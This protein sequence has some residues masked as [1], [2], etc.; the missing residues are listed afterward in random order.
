[1]TLP[2]FTDD[3]MPSGGRYVLGMERLLKAVQELSLVRDLE[4]VQQIVRTVARELTGCDG[5]SFVLN[6]GGTHCYYADEDAIEPLWKGLRFPQEICVSGWVM[7]HGQP[8]VIPD[9]YA[10]P[11]VPYEAYRPTFVKSMVMVPI[12]AMAPIGAIG[13]YWAKAHSPT[14]TEVRLLQ[15]LAD[16]TSVA[17]E[18]VSVYAELEHRVRARTEDL[19]RAHLEIQQLAVTDELTG[20]LNRRGFYEAA[21][22]A[23]AR[24]VPILLVSIDADGLK[25]VNDTLGHA[26]GDTMLADIAETLRTCFRASDIIA[27]M[28][29]DEYCVM[30]IDPGIDEAALREI[31]LRRIEEANAARP[32]AY[33]LAASFG[34]IAVP[35][36]APEDLDHW[37]IEVDRRMYVEK[38]ARKGRVRAV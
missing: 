36:A 12:R 25:G 35:D 31:L 29:G 32:R 6:E 16:A 7:R 11:R 2:S 30:M 20:L 13:N 19:T 15:A 1:M 17:M 18:N 8:A 24:K 4:G 14:D 37:L 26:V 21:R 9:I 3:P 28:G 23:L 27:R 38:T 34:C 10:D 22:L 33:H 5:A